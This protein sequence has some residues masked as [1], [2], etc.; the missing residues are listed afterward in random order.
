MIAFFRMNVSRG[1]DMVSKTWK[2]ML[3]ATAVS[4]MTIMAAEQVP[5]RGPS[6][7]SFEVHTDRDAA[8]VRLLTISRQGLNRSEL[9]LTTAQKAEINKIVDVYVSEL[10]NLSSK[11]PPDKS[12]K[13][14]HAAMQEQEAAQTTLNTALS[15]VMNEEQRRTW[16]LGLNSRRSTTNLSTVGTFPRDARN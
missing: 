3:V 7:S 9:N 8:R 5:Q 13:P 6:A 10:R 1:D 14:N 2:A 15:R 4:T 16:A 12:A 11:Y